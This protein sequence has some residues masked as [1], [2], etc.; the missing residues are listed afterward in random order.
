M[1]FLGRMRSLLWIK[2]GMCRASEHW[3]I[4]TAHSGCENKRKTWFSELTICKVTPEQQKQKSFSSSFFSQGKTRGVERLQ[5]AFLWCTR[6]EIFHIFQGERNE[7]CNFSFWR[8]PCLIW[9]RCFR[10]DI[11][12]LHSVFALIWQGLKDEVVTLEEKL[13]QQSAGAAATNTTSG[14]EADAKNLQLQEQIKVSVSCFISRA[15]PSLRCCRGL[16]DLE[17]HWSGLHGRR[18]HP[19]SFWGCTG[20]QMDGTFG[21][22][23]Q[24]FKPR[25]AAYVSHHTIVVIGVI[26]EDGVVWIDLPPLANSTQLNWK[27]NTWFVMAPRIMTDC[28]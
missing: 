3:T 10:V 24:L 27:G 5:A 2:I 16:A 1:G 20:W 9:L 21:K 4:T 19:G 15:L 18:L 17:S 22:K 7:R 14:A 8:I 13:E 11:R 25:E 6:L 23:M 26:I 12:W 28:K